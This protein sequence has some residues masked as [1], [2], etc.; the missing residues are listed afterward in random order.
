MDYKNYKISIF[1][2][3][4]ELDYFLSFTEFKNT[5]SKELYVLDISDFI[6]Y[7]HDLYIFT[8]YNLYLFNSIKF[9][10]SSNIYIHSNKSLINILQPNIYKLTGTYSTSNDMKKNIVKLNFDNIENLTG[11]GY[12][13][14][15]LNRRYFSSY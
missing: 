5:L 7:G 15:S 9:V 12:S 11:S 2:R 14:K 6:K 13:N 4:I 10:F 8:I 1:D 3:N